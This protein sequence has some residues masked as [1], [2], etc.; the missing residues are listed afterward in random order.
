MTIGFFIKDPFKYCPHNKVLSN[1]SICHAIYI[2]FMSISNIY[3]KRKQYKIYK[4]FS[5]I[6]FKNKILEIIYVPAIS[7]FIE[8]F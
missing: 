8:R 7:L 4:S 1:L 2:N 5:A 3:K 6:I